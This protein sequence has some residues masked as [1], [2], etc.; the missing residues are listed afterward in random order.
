VSASLAA[1]A[2]RHLEK[3]VTLASL[4]DA[5]NEVLTPQDAPAATDGSRVSSRR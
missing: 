3:P 2:D 5:M 4:L 1:G